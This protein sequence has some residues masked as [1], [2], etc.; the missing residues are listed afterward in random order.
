MEEELSQLALCLIDGPHVELLRAK[1]KTTNK[2]VHMEKRK[3]S[4][5]FPP[6][7]QFCPKKNQIDVAA[8]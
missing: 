6:Q 5:S 8:I 4:F 7:T 2:N 3:P 1:K